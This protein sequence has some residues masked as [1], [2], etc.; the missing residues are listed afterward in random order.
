MKFSPRSNSD[1]DLS[2]EILTKKE[3][4]FLLTFPAADKKQIWLRE[5][6]DLI[7]RLKPKGGKLDIVGHYL[8]SYL[9][10]NMCSFWS[11]ALRTARSRKE[12]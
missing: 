5:I 6:K 10:V 4:R 7:N 9:R 3:E 1:S 8:E 2:F 12:T 11:S